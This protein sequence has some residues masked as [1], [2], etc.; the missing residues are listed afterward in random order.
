MEKI[1]TTLP[2]VYIIEPK[3]FGDHRGYFMETYSTKV[4]E[5]MGITNDFV[6]DNQSYSAQ[7]GILRGIHFQ[8][9]PM[10]Q[11][12]LVRVTKGAVMDVAVD[13]RKGSPTYKQWVGVEL[14]ADNKRMLFIPRGFGHGFVTLTEDVE[15]CYKV[16]NLYSKECD[17]GIRFNDPSIGVDWGIDDPILSQKDTTSPM[18]EDSDCNFVYGE[19]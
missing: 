17:R 11:A 18:L 15:F 13:L 3:V 1:A 6:Q 5:E 9:A 8:N 14:S 10:A 19:I 4:F 16:D 7:K 12:K 2:G